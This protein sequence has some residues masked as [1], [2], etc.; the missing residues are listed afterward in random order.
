MV[1]DIGCEGVWVEAGELGETGIRLMKCTGC[2]EVWALMDTRS[3]GTFP[4]GTPDMDIIR[5][6]IA[7]KRGY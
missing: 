6:V 3:F 1:G 4:Q 7:Q 5:S 2:L